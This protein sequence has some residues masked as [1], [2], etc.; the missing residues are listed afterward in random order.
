MA[1]ERK[2]VLVTS[3]GKKYAG[4]VDVPNNTLRTTDLLNSGSIFWKDPSEKCFENAILMHDTLLKID[5]SSVCVKFDRIQVKL[6]EVI[7]FYDDLETI[8]DE[9]EKLRAA[10]M[11]QKT[12]EKVQTVNIITT[13]V[14]GSFY[15]LTGSFYGLFK[16]KS[17]DKFIPLT[18]VKLI[19]IYKKE[20]KWF[21]K[22]IELPY[23]FIGISTKHIEALRIR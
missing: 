10:S 9:K 4:K 21:Q 12:H 18:D 11:V 19:E 22:E 20:G 23:R 7:L 8:A 16:K 13:E 5:D 15:N 3:L 1:E 14:A 17:N 2:I 6:S